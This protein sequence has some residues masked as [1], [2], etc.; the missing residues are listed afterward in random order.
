MG[1]KVCNPRDARASQKNFWDKI[2]SINKS[3][4]VFSGSHNGGKAWY[5]ENG[6]ETITILK[7]K[8]YL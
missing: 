7:K 5:R 2:D 4:L 3:D 1:K 8:W 6:N